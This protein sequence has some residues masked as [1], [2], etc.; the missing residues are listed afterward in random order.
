MNI[1]N[2]EIERLGEVLSLARQS[3]GWST[4]ELAQQIGVTRQ[5][6]NNL[7]SG[8]GKLSKTQYM[9]IRCLFD[10][11]IELHPDETE[12]LKT[13]LEICVDN[14]D[15]YDDEAKKKIKDN[16]SLLAPGVTKDP[17]KRKEASKMWTAVVVGLG[18][19][20]PISTLTALAIGKWRRK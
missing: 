14:P 1:T 8:R 13:L 10:D 3:L 15:K 12:M 5:T 9:A 6:I 18:I 7:E 4:E 17:E 19:L 11:E 2:E 20:A 16:I